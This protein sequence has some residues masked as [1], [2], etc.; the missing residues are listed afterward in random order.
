M[1]RF[2]E[3]KFTIK[4]SYLGILNIDKGIDT[5]QRTFT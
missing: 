4:L 5:G 2:D 1:K 3:F